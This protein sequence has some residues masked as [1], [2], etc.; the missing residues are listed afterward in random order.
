M[1]RNI[2]F[3]VAIL[4]FFGGGIYIILQ[5][6]AQPQPVSVEEARPSPSPTPPAP[7]ASS[8]HRQPLTSF[9]VSFLQ[10]N[11]RQPLSILLLQIILI[12]TAARLAGTLFLKIGQPAVIG[13]MVAGIL[14]GPSV[15]GFLSPSALQ[16][17]FPPSSMETLRLL[18]QIGVIIF[19]FIV[20]MEINVRHLRE[21]AE[22]AIIISHAS[23]IV[24]FFLGGT[25][26]LLIYP[27]LSGSGISFTAFAPF[28]G[29]AM[30]ITAFPV[31]ARI[32]EEHGIAKSYLGSVAIACAAID[33]ATAW[34]LL[35]MVVALVRAS[36][37]GAA[38]FTI[39]LALL[40]TAAMIFLFKPWLER[41][42]DK[43]RKSATLNRGW[44]TVLLAFVFTSALI[45]EIIGIHALFGAFLAGAVMPA[46]AELRAHLRER[47]EAFSS[48][49]LLPL[50]FAFTGLRTQINLLSDGNSWL[51]CAGVIGVAVVGKMG[52]SM[53]A[54]RWTGMNWRDA[55]A[56]GALMNTR[57]LVELIAL[58][59]GY[60]LGVLPARIFAI[61][62]LMAL[63]TT[64]MTG[65]LLRLVNLYE[66]EP[67]PTAARLDPPSGRGAAVSG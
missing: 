57:G 46:S 19:M 47:L 13:E 34:C 60:D 43:R 5:A 9:T 4:L 12:I 21:K 33:D 27:G 28:M 10:D 32:I 7:A 14:L 2:L 63:V 45:T 50:F 36:A 11:L 41:L 61:M 38:V 56:I 54:A 65:P 20:G 52:G 39:L 24:P 40:F 37:P 67:L 59:I 3:Y 25:L 29:I 6:G 48:A 15:L 66:R 51:L 55:F 62:V 35:A 58:N 30:S 26:A 23:I 31:L 18:S 44:V 64:A 22:S 1:K 16:F 8:E 53:L 42:L 17:L 49:S